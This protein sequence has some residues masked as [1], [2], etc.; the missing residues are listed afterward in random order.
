M[1]VIVRLAV[2]AAVG[3]LIATIANRTAVA[4]LATRSEEALYGLRGRA[5]A[6]IHRLS[7][8][9]HAEERRGA[10]V[11]R[12][13][14]DV[15]T[16]SQFSL[17]RDRLAARRHADGGGRDH[18][19]HLLAAA[20]FCRGG[21]R[22]RSSRAARAAE[23]LSRPTPRCAQRN[24]QTLAAVSESVMGAAVVRAYRVRAR[25]TAGC[26][27][28][29]T[30]SAPTAS[31]RPAGRAAVPLGR[32]LLGVH[33]GRWSSPSGWPGPGVGSHD[34]RD[35]RASLPRLP[36]PGTHRRV[37]RDPRPDPDGLAGWRQVLALLEIAARDRR[38]GRASSSA[39]PPRIEVRATSLRATGPPARCRRS[40]PALRR[41]LHDPAD[42]PSPSSGR[43]ARASRRG[44]AAVR[45]WP[46]PRRARC[47]RRGSTCVTCAGLAASTVMVPQEPSCSTPRSWRTCGSARRRDRRRG[48]PRVLRAGAGAV[49]RRAVRR[50]RHRGRR[51]G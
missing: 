46:T 8:A 45:G 5:F 35:G 14:S 44:Q 7:I 40:A 13:T 12:I 30:A 25:T 17:G 31:G 37:H 23:R 51:A 33:G 18:H 27:T 42:R 16:L 34:R 41:Q 22:S 36:L 26:A 6:H 1:D 29:S 49:A 48:R 50:P 21:A 32:G 24:G 39:G 4:R 11:S 19:V 2:I 15:E 9:D 20:G 28:P 38:P 3:I 43:P 47:G 10:L